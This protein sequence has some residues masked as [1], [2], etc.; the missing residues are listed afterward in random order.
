MSAND[1]PSERRHA[2]DAVE[3]AFSEMNPKTRGTLLPPV[4]QPHMRFEFDNPHW[5]DKW[6]DDMAAQMPT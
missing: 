5:S 2:K 4:G 6:S 3:Y 1:K